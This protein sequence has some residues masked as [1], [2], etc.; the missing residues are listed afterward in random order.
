MFVVI[1]LLVCG[2][3]V[4]KISLNT[5]IISDNNGVSHIWSLVEGEKNSYFVSQQ[6]SESE[7]KMFYWPKDQ[8]SKHISNLNKIR[9][10][11]RVM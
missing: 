7:W 11:N 1:L 10:Y 6:N 3:E 8:S 4:V 2:C 5:D 9:G